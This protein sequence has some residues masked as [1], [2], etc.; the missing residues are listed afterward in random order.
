MARKIKCPDLLKNPDI[1]QLKEM[2]IDYMLG[3]CNHVDCD[4][5]HYMYETVIEVFYGEKAW[6]YINGRG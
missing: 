3:D 2:A 1:S 6:K 5:K 4:C